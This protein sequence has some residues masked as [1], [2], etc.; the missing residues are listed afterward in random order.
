MNNLDY[1]KSYHSNIRLKL[2]NISV[3]LD[4]LGNPHKALRYIHIAGTNGKGSVCS[5]LEEMLVHSGKKTGCFSSPELIKRNETIRINKEDISDE[6]LNALLFEVH[7]AASRMESF[8][9]PYEVLC[10][11]AFLHF[12]NHCCDYVILEAGMGGEG[13]AT[14]IIDS[15][16]IAVITKIALDHTAYLGNTAEEIARVK[17]G[18]IKKSCTLITTEEN[19]SLDRVFRKKCR[20]ADAR[21]IYAQKL[22][23]DGYEDIFERVCLYGQ[24]ATL[25]LGGVMQKENAALAVKAAEILK[26][27]KESILYGLSSAKNPARFEKLADKL[28]FDGAHNPDGTLSLKSSLDRYMPL[29]KKAFIMGV[30][31]DKDFPLMLRILKDDSCGFYFV[32]VKSNERAMP[33]EEMKRLAETLGIKA[34]T[35]PDIQAA[36]N[37]AASAYEKIILCG[38]L[39]MYKEIYL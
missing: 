4:L 26:T 23:S 17:S 22:L 5:F 30:M 2:D 37:R 39:Y 9:S 8:P 34:E 20:A 33:K 13:D 28:Y 18:I 14:N 12:K 15:C 3:L 1:A 10:A 6:E 32:D 21:L 31:R 29:K 25:S 19:A 36:I 16:E 7:G 11:A 38:S 27:D 35:A 24:A